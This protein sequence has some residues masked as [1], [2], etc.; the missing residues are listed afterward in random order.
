MM[1]PLVNRADE[2]MLE[3]TPFPIAHSSPGAGV[4]QNAAADHARYCVGRS[5]EDLSFES[6]IDPG[7]DLRDRCVVISACRQG[8]HLNRA[9]SYVAIE[10]NELSLVHSTAGNARIA[11]QAKI[12]GQDLLKEV[13]LATCQSTQPS[14]KRDF[15]SL[16]TCTYVK[17]SISSFRPKY[18]ASARK[19]TIYPEDV[20]FG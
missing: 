19:M 12:F 4:G 3:A 17:H 11:S 1:Y 2:M 7:E 18:H 16:T 9:L 8:K 14:T 13:H 5:A 20:P 6:F 10:L 15:H